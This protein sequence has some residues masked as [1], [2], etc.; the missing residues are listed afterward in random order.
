[1]GNLNGFSIHFACILTYNHLQIDQKRAEIANFQWFFN[2]F[3]MHITRARTEKAQKKGRNCSLSMGFQC[4]LHAYDLQ[5]SKKG[6]KLRTLNGFSM[7][8]ARILPSNASRYL[9][10]LISSSY[11]TRYLNYLCSSTIP[12][13]HT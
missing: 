9:T 8:F 6:Q 10:F 4:I 11:Q 3:C 2:A 7:H 1:M 12:D 5:I 13:G